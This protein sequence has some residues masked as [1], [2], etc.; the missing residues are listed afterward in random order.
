MR[1]AQMCAPHDIL[2]PSLFYI[3]IICII[4]GPF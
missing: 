2:F 1:H 3:E 4:F